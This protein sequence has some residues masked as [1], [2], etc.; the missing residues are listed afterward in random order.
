MNV[1][2]TLINETTTFR[3]NSTQSEITQTLHRVHAFPVTRLQLSRISF[4]KI[5]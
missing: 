1:L 5:C 4:L 2:E 3:D